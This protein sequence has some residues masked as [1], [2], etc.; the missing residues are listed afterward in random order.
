MPHL[1]LT[2][3]ACAALLTVLALQPAPAPAQSIDPARLAPRDAWIFLGVTDMD[4]FW[5][6][7]ERTAAFAAMRDP[8]GEALAEYSFLSKLVERGR[9]A[10]GRAL[11]T[12][13]DR[14]ASPFGG[15]L[16]AYLVAP[17]QAGESPGAVL[18]LGVDDAELMRGYFD[19]AI[20][21]FKQLA[22][23]YE[24]VSAGDV[25][26]HAFRS[27][28][29]EPTSAAADDLPFD[30]NTDPTTLD[31]EA[32]DQFAEAMF[33]ELLSGE[34]LPP[35]LSLALSD[36]R[37]YVADTVE[38][39]R[40]ALRLARGGE[41]LADD[42]DYRLIEQKFSPAG[43]MRFM[44]NTPA[45]VAHLRRESESFADA[46]AL[47]GLGSFGPL[48]GHAGFG[49]PDSFESRMD[50]L[51]LI[52][53]QRTG[54]ARILTPPNAEVAPPREISTENVLYA[55]LNLGRADLLDEI[56]RMVRRKN[57][58]AADQMSQ[59]LGEVQTP[60]G[61]LNIRKD[62]I[63]NIQPPVRY[64]L[65]FAR[66][67]GPDSVR[68]A[69]SVGHRDRAAMTR[70]L[71]L[72]ARSSPMPLTDRELNGHVLWE[73]PVG[74]F[75]LTA[76]NDQVVFGS[77][78]TVEALVRGE[79]AG[80][81]LAESRQF[82]AAARHQPAEAWAV[83]YVDSR[84]MFEAMIALSRQRDQIMANAMGNPSAMMALA[85]AEGMTASLKPNELDQA[86]RLVK[87]QSAGMLTL[88]T[89]PDGIL[90]SQVTLRP[91]E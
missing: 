36:D 32:M 71:S 40:A 27:E 51:A 69:L 44:L 43:P 83:L 68:M 2:R 11:D 31:D 29:R 1:S 25:Q 52:R 61:P 23:G 54:L 10:L 7:L 13:P 86:E 50:L 58:Q 55:S 17:P 16:A 78:V 3:L 22:D 34:N 9:E 39:V 47:L 80:E 33:G 20:G 42:E 59:S 67:I 91:S 63:D 64:L 89:T 48:I 85:M 28:P 4:A 19:T 38:H 5:Q 15:P 56:E 82:R 30:P 53:G 14:L 41:S 35:R 57:P 81:P 90:I 74:G 24:Q 60:D 26:I 76:T 6:E 88:S 45:I 77:V 72:I 66:P 8:A 49:E 37:L 70:L 12:S 73:T 62:V 79:R 46:A 18:I 84:R 21:K 65:G 75:A 87:Y